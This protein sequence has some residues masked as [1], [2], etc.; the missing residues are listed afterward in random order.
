MY[1]TGDGVEKDYQQA[2]KWYRAAADQGYAWALTNLGCMY[3][4]GLGVKLDLN[5]AAK[6]YELAAQEGDEMAQ[7]NLVVIRRRASEQTAKSL[8]RH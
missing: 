5:E 6:W 3:A 8:E 1:E 7:R 2:L 4:K